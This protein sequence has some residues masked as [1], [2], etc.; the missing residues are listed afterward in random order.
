MANEI[1][2][3]D[4]IGKGRIAAI[5]SASLHNNLYDAVGLRGAMTFYDY[6]GAGS[7]TQNITTVTRGNPMVAASSETSGGAS[8][9]VLTASQ[10]QLA[11]A[12]YLLKFQVGDLFHL[13]GRGQPMNIDVVLSILSEALELTLTDLLTALFPSV[14][15]NVGTSGVNMSSSDLYDAIFYLA[16][17]NNRARQLYGI[18]HGQQC[19]DLM[20][21][22]RSEVGPAQMREDAQRAVGLQGIREGDGLRFSFAGVDVH[23]CNSVTLDGGSANRVG[24]IFAPGAFGYTLAPVTD[25]DPLF[26]PDDILVGTP[27]FFVE[28]SRNAD[29]AL[30]SLIAN[31]YPGVVE[32]EDLRAVRVTT[33]A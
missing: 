31:A 9:A 29:D 10:V 19:N 33:D 2:F 6:T 15:G 21:S 17:N 16:L 1:T 28:R 3:N 7:K 4:Y 23:Q 26:D 32:V 12:R 25:M 11:V 20:Q 18:L 5:I 13:T 27:E 22:L 30:S 8:N 24:C 14:V